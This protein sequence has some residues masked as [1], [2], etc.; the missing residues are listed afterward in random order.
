M[1]TKIWILV[2][3]TTVLLAIVGFIV[4]LIVSYI[5]KELGVLDTS[6][7]EHSIE[8]AKNTEQLKSLF[9]LLSRIADNNEAFEKRITK[10]EI[11]QQAV[12]E[13]CAIYH[14]DQTV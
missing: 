8:L 12:K 1:E 4:K 5:K 7:S 6:V 13:R 3:V 10:L 14:K 9:K 11:G 2:G